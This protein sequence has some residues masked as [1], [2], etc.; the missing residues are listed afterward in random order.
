MKTK[1]VDRQV[2]IAE[3][4]K[5]LGVAK[6]TLRRWVA[7]KYVI[8]KRHPFNNYRLFDREELERVFMELQK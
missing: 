7:K 1:R 3:A 2:M 4:A 6:D 8:A 5:M